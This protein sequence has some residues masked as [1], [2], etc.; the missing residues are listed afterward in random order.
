VM[1]RLTTAVIALALILT[2]QGRNHNRVS[3]PETHHSRAAGRLQSRWDP[4][5]TYSNPFGV[6]RWVRRSRR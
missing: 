1:Q 6:P 4:G 3:K 2:A 5:Y